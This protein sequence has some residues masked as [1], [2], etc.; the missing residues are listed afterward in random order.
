MPLHVLLQTVFV[1]TFAFQ[2]SGGVVAISHF[3]T[4]HARVTVGV[5]SLTDSFF[6]TSRCFF[7]RGRLALPVL[8]E[9]LVGVV[10][11]RLA[12]PRMR[13]TY[14]SGLRWLFALV[15]IV[16]QEGVNT[17]GSPDRFNVRQRVAIRS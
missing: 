12:S 8:A 7:Q 3:E 6:Y 1:R 16:Y 11:V 2:H 5:G 14:A 17:I 4:W 9:L 10:E 15:R 13:A